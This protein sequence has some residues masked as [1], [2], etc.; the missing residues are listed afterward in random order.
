MKKLNLTE[1]KE[2]AGGVKCLCC[3][4]WVRFGDDD[5]M[6]R[7]HEA[8]SQS[9]CRHDCCDIRG[10]RYWGYGSQELKTC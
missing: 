8:S 1:A 7:I 2:V 9:E 3:N 4:D 10:T 5:W 6:K